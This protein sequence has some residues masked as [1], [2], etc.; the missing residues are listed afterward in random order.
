M[1]STH[2]EELK[3]FFF[4]QKMLLDTWRKKKKKIPTSKFKAE[5]II[6]N[7]V[8]LKAFALKS[9]TRQDAHSHH[10]YSS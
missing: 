7:G 1:T 8:K 10:F 3:K 4:S 9:G 5:Y 6:L 2:F